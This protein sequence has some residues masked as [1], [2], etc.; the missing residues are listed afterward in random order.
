LADE[1]Q[2]PVFYMNDKEKL[3]KALGIQ[4]NCEPKDIKILVNG[5]DILKTLIIDS[6]VIMIEKKVS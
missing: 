1:Y 2:S 4:L 6:V 3:V 5:I